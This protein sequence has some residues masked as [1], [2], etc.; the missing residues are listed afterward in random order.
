MPE[1]EEKVNHSRELGLLLGL[2]AGLPCAVVVLLIIIRVCLKCRRRYLEPETI[3]LPLRMNQQI[4]ALIVDCGPSDE[5]GKILDLLKKHNGKAMFFV[6]GGEQIGEH[7]EMLQRIHNEGHE[8]G[9]HPLRSGGVGSIEGLKFAEL[10][11]YIK[12]VEALLPANPDGAKY[13]RLTAAP[14]SKENK[15]ANNL[16]RELG[17]ILVKGEILP[18]VLP[19][20]KIDAGMVIPIIGREDETIR[21]TEEML[22]RL[23]EEKLKAETVGQFLRVAGEQMEQTLRGNQSNPVNGTSIEWIANWTPRPN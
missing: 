9:I 4:V 21:R 22:I 23:D 20:A 17:Y 16:I 5:T 11:R 15:K 12:A 3:A 8:L 18:V 7:Q 1:T 2:A 10:E 13:L 14:G 6:T 19:N